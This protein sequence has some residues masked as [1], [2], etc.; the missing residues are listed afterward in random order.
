M[1]LQF[2]VYVSEDQ[3][4]HNIFFIPCKCMSNCTRVRLVNWDGLPWNIVSYN[5]FKHISMR[6]II[7][8]CL[9]EILGVYPTFCC[10]RP[11]T[12]QTFKFKSF[13]R[14][15]WNNYRKICVI[16]MQWRQKFHQ[17]LKHYLENILRHYYFICY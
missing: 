8:K 17:M 3:Y 11:T 7:D 10:C 2:I 15:P 1:W 9:L 12:S 14:I 6:I 4:L 13:P 5:D 16:P